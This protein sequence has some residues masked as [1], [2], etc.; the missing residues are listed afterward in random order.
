[1]RV[2]DIVDLTETSHGSFAEHS[3]EKFLSVRDKDIYELLKLFNQRNIIIDTRNSEKEISYEILGE[4]RKSLIPFEIKVNEN[5]TIANITKYILNNSNLKI[6]VGDYF[7]SEGGSSIGGMDLAGGSYGIKGGIM[8][9]IVFEG[10]D[11]PVGVVSDVKRTLK[12]FY[13]SDNSYE[14]D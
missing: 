11:S 8:C 9:K 7:K 12:E 4:K 10:E 14:F 13:K 5:E 1:M 2:E 3:E 6:E